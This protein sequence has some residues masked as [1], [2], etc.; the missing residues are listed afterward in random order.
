[1]CSLSLCIT[2]SDGEPSK[3]QS[4]WFTKLLIAGIS[5]GAGATGVM[6]EHEDEIVVRKAPQDAVE[7]LKE[8]PLPISRLLIGHN[9][10]PT[11]GDR[12]INTNNHPVQVGR[13]IVVHNGMV[14]SPNRNL[15]ENGIEYPNDVVDTYLIPAYINRFV[16]S[17]LDVPSAIIKMAENVTG[18]MACILVD[19]ED[20]DTL[21]VWRRNSPL[22]L[23]YLPK[24]DVLLGASD[25]AFIEYATSINKSYMNGLFQTQKNNVE[26]SHHAVTDDSGMIINTRTWDWSPFKLPFG[27]A[28]STGYR[29]SSTT[30]N[31]ASKAT[32]PLPVKH[33]DSQPSPKLNGSEQNEIAENITKA[34]GENIG[35]TFNTWF[36]MLCEKDHAKNLYDDC[37]QARIDI[38]AR[39]RPA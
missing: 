9:R 36:C 23:A 6:V 39:T 15:H 3:Q 27:H 25:K 21:Y 17:G 37:D 2:G 24:H 10:A 33:A 20:K 30:S 4:A 22:H 32:T 1:M 12:A 14:D 34:K 13:F 5:R 18:S 26:M 11:R 38:E 31:N 35:R 28:W 8:N 29:G 16:D 19:V 7:F